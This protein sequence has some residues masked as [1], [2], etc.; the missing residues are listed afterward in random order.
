VGAEQAEQAE[1]EA[2]AREEEQA[3]MDPVGTQAA[4]VQRVA[5]IAPSL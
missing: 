1:Q 5:N 3:T 4:R 2:G